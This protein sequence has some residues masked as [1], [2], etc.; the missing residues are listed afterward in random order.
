MSRIDRLVRGGQ[1]GPFLLDPGPQARPGVGQG[2]VGEGDVIA[3]EDDQARPDERIQGPSHRGDL[4]RVFQI[5]QRQPGPGIFRFAS[6]RDQAQQETTR[7]TLIR[8][9]HRGVRSLRP[10]GNVIGAVRMILFSP[11]F[12]VSPA[13]PG[14][15]TTPLRRSLIIG[16]I[17]VPEE[18]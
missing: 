18:Y 16:F 9:I 7:H 11:Q 6:E 12:P 14:C 17:V 1:D 3:V 10:L 13:I 2:L 15:V 5:D 8:V 4:V